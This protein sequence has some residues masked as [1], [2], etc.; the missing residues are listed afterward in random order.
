MKPNS[1]GKQQ[2]EAMY[3]VAG[4]Q[5]GMIF[6]SLLAPR[7]GVYVL[8]DAMRLSGEFDVAA[9]LDAW[10]F[11]IARHPV[12][13][14]L[15]VRL[16]TEKPVQVV[17]KEVELPLVELDWRDLD[18]EAREAAF[19][20]LLREEQERGFDFS[21]APLMRL[22][23]ARIAQ[24]AWYF[25][26]T[27]HHVLID[28]WS[29]PIVLGDVLACYTQRCRGEA[30]DTTPV[31]GYQEFVRWLAAQDSDAARA[32]WRD[33]LATLDERTPA[34]LAGPAPAG[35]RRAEELRA[36][37]V[38]LP[39]GL[40]RSLERFAREEKVTPSVLMQAAWAL[41]LSSYAGRDAICFG[42][43]VSGRPAALTGVERIVGPFIN[44]VPLRATVDPR[45]RLGDWLRDLQ[46]ANLARADVEYLPLADIQ[47]LAA[48]GD[49]GLF[50][51]LLVFDNYPTAGDGSGDGSTVRAELLSSFS[52]NNYALTLVVMPGEELRLLFKYDGARYD[53]ATVERLLADLA[54]IVARFPG[55]AAQP[56]AVLGP[57]DA[58]ARDDAIAAGQGPALAIAP[59]GIP[60]L[61]AATVAEA[62]G[63][64]AL[65]SGDETLT[66]EE[67]D[68]RSNHLA[69]LLRAYGAGPETRVGLC[70]RR[71]PHFVNGLL[72]ILKA[73]AAYVPLD[74][75]WPAQRLA[76]V[77]DAA[78]IDLVV[79]EQALLD[80]VAGDGERTL[81]SLDRDADEIASFPDDAL[82]PVAPQQLAYVIYT[83]GSTGVPKGVGI[84]HAA[85][86]E[87]VAG[88]LARLDL[89]EPAE[90][91]ALS[92]LAADLGYTALYGALC[93]G[94][95]LRLFAE[96]LTLDAPALAAELRRRPVDVLKI[97]PSH[98]EALLA[99]SDPALL[100]RRCLVV[101]GE[102]PSPALLDKVRSLGDCRIVNHYGPTET[103]VGALCADL[104]VRVPV[105]VGTPL[106]GRSAYVLDRALGFV[107]AGATGELHLGGAGL[108]RGYLGDAAQTAE[109]FVPNPHATTPGE[110]LY[111]SGDRARTLDDGRVEYLGRLDQQI[112][113]RGQRIE[114]GEI[115]AV[116][117]GVAG[118]AAAA[119]ALRT[120]ADGA[121]RLVAYLVPADGYD[122]DAA[123]LAC[124]QRLPEAMHPAQWVRLDRLPLTP[125]GKLDRKALPEAQA[126]AA[127]A[128]VAPRSGTEEALA[129]LW[130]ELLKCERVGVDDN[131]FALGGN[132]LLIIQLHGRLRKQFDAATSVVEL[133]KYPTIARLAE[134]LRGN[135]DA[136]RDA[137]RRSAERQRERQAG[138]RAQEDLID[139]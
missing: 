88:V 20:A 64:F 59:A 137:L 31:R 57:F 17:L 81:V 11:V 15:F 28:G 69:H 102:S 16:D 74:G 105:A 72:G 92:T 43:T 66:Y 26:W 7:S 30:P 35:E 108:A 24:D 70:T 109:R 8:Q 85:M 56:L 132:S 29:S 133:F 49:G 75:D 77:L 33:Q 84:S 61:F 60:A 119:V 68:R 1:A 136:G 114:I 3:P 14:T 34:P 135:G 106:A 130:C 104:T 94:H 25:V 63:R 2:V 100:P 76:D 18:A 47:S 90:L 65:V 42:V 71:N 54:R 41:V 117:R 83:S 12:F 6:H 10:R 46:Q 122:E 82:P 111:R 139:A 40:S 113:L 123:R 138:R 93:G 89:R 48:A 73:G 38:H 80:A 103:T 134:H 96:A 21:K 131:F 118:V 87:Y 67:L 97:V 52:Y 107:P 127:P 121:P 110:R 51:T 58:A 50:D 37:A 4:I 44:T 45:Q 91:A 112:K 125:N 62:P 5:R 19:A 95:T 32:Y 55:G 126:E 116:L 128:Y 36:A 22:H 115:E 101:G 78:G 120:P 39:A 129:A 98:L 13:R 86:H 53:A 79:T 27:R 9:F 23:L 99:T 124:R